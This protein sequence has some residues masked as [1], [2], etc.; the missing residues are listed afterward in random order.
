MHLFMGIN[1]YI[2]YILLHLQLF[3]QDNLQNSQSVLQE[4]I[5]NSDS[6][7]I[8]DIKSSTWLDHFDR[9][10]TFA[11]HLVSATLFHSFDITY[12][13]RSN[14]GIDHCLIVVGRKID[15]RYTVDLQW[16][17]H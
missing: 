10:M 2:H 8:M 1:S 14:A 6:P 15:I 13:Q 11:K 9:V 16:L 3:L 4:R 17:E 5:G 12:K 7:L